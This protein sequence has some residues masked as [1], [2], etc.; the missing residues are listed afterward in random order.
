MRA[1]AAWP[2]R[3]SRVGGGG[4]ATAAQQL[5]DQPVTVELG[6]GEHADDPEV[7]EPVGPAPLLVLTTLGERHHHGGRTRS[8]QIHRRVVAALAQRDRRAAQLVAEVV[9]SAYGIELV[10]APLLALQPRPHR[11]GQERPGHDGG[12]QTGPR[13][14]LTMG[15]DG[16]PDQRL[17]DHAAAGGHQHPRQPLDRSRAVGAG[18]ATKP[19]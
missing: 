9:D 17:A 7:G 3:S 19:V 10:R 5:V 14:H 4:E 8:Q 16:G 12:P 15:A 18:G 2:S 11:F 6:V 1:V 13:G